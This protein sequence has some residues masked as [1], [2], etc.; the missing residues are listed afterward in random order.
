MGKHVKRAK[1]LEQARG[2]R[3]LVEL[4]EAL[5]ELEDE[6]RTTLLELK[7]WNT[8]AEIAQLLGVS[9]Q[10]I[11]RQVARARTR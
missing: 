9:R 4:D 6:R 3:R 8:D 5:Q 7:R 2:R 11:S 1:A 10:A